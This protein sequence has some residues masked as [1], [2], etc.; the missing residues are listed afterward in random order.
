MGEE[1]SEFTELEMALQ[2]LRDSIAKMDQHLELRAKTSAERET[3][4]SKTII[5]NEPQ[6]NEMTSGTSDHPDQLPQEQGEA[7][8]HPSINQ[9]KGAGSAGPEATLEDTVQTSDAEDKLEQDKECAKDVQTHLYC[10][11]HY[12]TVC[13]KLQACL[14]HNQETGKHGVNAGRDD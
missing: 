5:T 2:G 14:R 4:H 12:S 6:C 3:I 9:S 10:T 13:R 8:N 11:R 7:S 1:V